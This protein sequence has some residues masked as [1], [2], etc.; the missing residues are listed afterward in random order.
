LDAAQALTQT[1]LRFARRFL[2]MEELAQEPAGSL[3]GGG[4]SSLL[5]GRSFQELEV[6]WQQAKQEYP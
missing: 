4:K 6:L 2:R 3:P 5:K 1:N